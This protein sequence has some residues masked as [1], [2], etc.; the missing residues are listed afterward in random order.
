MFAHPL[1]LAFALLSYIKPNQTADFKRSICSNEGQAIQCCGDR[2]MLV[3]VHVALIDQ[4]VYQ[5]FG[6]L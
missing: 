3:F 6:L 4:P 2:K 5:L 1:H